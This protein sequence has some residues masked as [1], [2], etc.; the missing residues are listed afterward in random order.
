M[1]RTLITSLDVDAISKLAS[2]I[3]E[4]NDIDIDLNYD[5]NTGELTT[6]DD[7]IF[8]KY[9][10]IESTDWEDQKTLQDHKLELKQALST[11]QYNGITIPLTTEKQSDIANEAIAALLIQANINPDEEFTITG[12]DGVLVLGNADDYI[13]FANSV[14]K[15]VKSARLAFATAKATFNQ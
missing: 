9:K 12:S 3:N 6:T 1:K 2:I 14:R 5:P 4:N 8:A 10:S 13:I 11:Y 15:Y 7:A